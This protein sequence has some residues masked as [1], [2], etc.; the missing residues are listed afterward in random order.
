MDGKYH[1]TYIPK[2]KKP[3]EDFLKAQGRFRHL[4]KKG[5]EWMIEEIQKEVDQRWEELLKLAGE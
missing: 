4:F 5:N 3:V 2:Q 1:I